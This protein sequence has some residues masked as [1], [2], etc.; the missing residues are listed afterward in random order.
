M[1][2]F[3]ATK[4]NGSADVKY[5]FFTTASGMVHSIDGYSGNFYSEIGF[6]TPET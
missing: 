3:R 5:N 1:G 6:V 4:W 2:R